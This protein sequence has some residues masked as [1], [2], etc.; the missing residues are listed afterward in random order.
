MS[1]GCS[2][3]WGYEKSVH[4]F[5]SEILN[6]RDHSGDLG[7]DGGIILRQILKE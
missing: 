2:T 5:L 7:L 1:V 4:I 3:L 6:V